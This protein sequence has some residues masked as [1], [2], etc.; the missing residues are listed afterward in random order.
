MS[1]DY[2]NQDDVDN[3]VDATNGRISTLRQSVVLE[4]ISEEVSQ[5]VEDVNVKNRLNLLF[6]DSIKSVEKVNNCLK[7]VA[8]RSYSSSCKKTEVL[9]ETINSDDKARAAIKTVPQFAQAVNNI[10]QH[11]VCM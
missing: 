5:S 10:K 1:I 2:N 11:E 3:L 6:Q 7:N 8:I 4:Q 9:L